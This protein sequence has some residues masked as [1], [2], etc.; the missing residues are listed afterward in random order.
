M[1]SKTWTHVIGLA[2]FITLALPFVS[3]AQEQ[4]TEHHHYKLIDVGTFGGPHSQYSVPSSAGLNNRGTATGVADTSIPDPNCFFDCFVDHAFVSKDGVT[5]DLVHY[6]VV[7]AA[8]P[9]PSTM[10]G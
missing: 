1:K 5:T 8:L 6:R 7:R 4:K 9:I 3:S 2:F 10:V